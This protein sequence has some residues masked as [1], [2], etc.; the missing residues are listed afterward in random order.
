MNGCCRTIK[1]I[2][3]S[4]LGSSAATTK[5]NGL[6]FIH[7]ILTYEM[8]ENKKKII[9]YADWLDMFEAMTDDEAG[10]LIKHF[11]RYVNDLN[12]KAPDR[13]TELVFEPIK[14]V[15][16][17]NLKH[18]E[19]RVE[20]N[21]NNGTKGGRPKTENNPNKPNGFLDNRKKPDNDNDKD[22]DN[23]N[24]KDNVILNNTSLS[25]NVSKEVE[26][27]AAKSQK[28]IRFIKPTISDI[29]VFT[30]ASNLNLNPDHFF[31]F[32]ESKDWM[33]GKNKMKD[34]KAAARNWA[35]RNETPQQNKNQKPL[36]QIDY[37]KQHINSHVY[38]SLRGFEQS[39]SI[40][41]GTLKV[42][43]HYLS[44]TTTV[45]DVHEFA[46]L[47]DQIENAGGIPDT[48][49]FGTP[50]WLGLRESEQN[51]NSGH[52]RLSLDGTG[53]FND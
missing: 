13:V 38:K 42:A 3:E 19:N 29:E 31:D 49:D 17:R 35:R 46:R 25:T 37:E 16:K 28:H 23:V 41:A 32:Y 53:E 2:I 34:W 22:N 33:V 7:L 24:D 26:Q 20:Q 12:P 15:L 43:R 5:L 47:L 1:N 11:F 4:P 51:D 50:L 14:A 27:Q 48:V 52:L 21:R 10:R 36:T 45:I 18:W 30:Q 44:Q 9:V 6:F 39:R 40:S 8:A